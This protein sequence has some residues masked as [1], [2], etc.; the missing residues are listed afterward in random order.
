MRNSC[1]HIFGGD[2]MSFGSRLKELRIEKKSSQKE[3]ASDIG[4]S[5][6][7]ISQYENDSRFPNEEMLKRLCTYYQISS[8]Y[9]LGL[10]DIKHAPLSKKEA[11]EKMMM[12]QQMDLIC[13]LINMIQ[14]EINKEDDNEN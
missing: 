5:I 6:T 7:T 2:G 4:I 14:P 12:S 9:L 13:N 11:K 10:T 8:D 3:V 1:Y